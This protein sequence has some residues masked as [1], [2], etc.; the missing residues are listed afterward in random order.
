MST[1]SSPSPA[2]IEWTDPQRQQAFGRWLAQQASTQG[3][4][5]NS[6][7]DAIHRIELLAGFAGYAGGEATLRGQIAAAI[8]LLVQ[9]A[10]LPSGKRRVMSITELRGMQGGELCFHD[11]FRFEPDTGTLV[12]R[13]AA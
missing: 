13:E 2:A 3:L 10:R 6:V 12:P 11:V 9:V 7:R 8:Q 1:S 4:H 5:A